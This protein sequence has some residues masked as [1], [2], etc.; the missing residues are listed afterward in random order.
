[1]P[2]E[3][4]AVAARTPV[5]RDYE[6]GALQRGWIRVRTSQEVDPAALKGSLSIEPAREYTVQG[7]GQSFTMHGKFEPGT[8]F[9]LHIA[10]GLESVLGGRTQ[11]DYDADIIIGNITPSFGFTSQSGLYMLLSGQRSLE[12]KTVNLNKLNVRVSQVFQNNLVFFLD[13]GRYYDYEYYNEGDD[14]EGG[15]AL[16]RGWGKAGADQV[17]GRIYLIILQADEQGDDAA[18][19]QTAGGGDARDAVAASGELLGEAVGVLVLD[20][21]DHHLHG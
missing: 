4:V 20:D 11:N 13:G 16:M 7:D 12:I 19:Q 3:L 2:R 14:E 9:R 17:N 10:K 6:D 18:A 8:A 5:V 15:A 21:H 1:M